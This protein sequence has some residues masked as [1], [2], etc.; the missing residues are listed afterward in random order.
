ME[1]TMITAVTVVLVVFLGCGTILAALRMRTLKYVDAVITER[2][3][4]ALNQHGGLKTTVYNILV[5]D[6]L[7]TGVEK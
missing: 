6:G 1:K 4:R 3:A 7:I 5:E 2:I